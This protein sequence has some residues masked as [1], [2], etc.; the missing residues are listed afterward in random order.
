LPVADAA[1]LTTSRTLPTDHPIAPVG[2]SQAPPGAGPPATGHRGREVGANGMRGG[3]LDDA[4]KET[5]GLEHASRCIQRRKPIFVQQMGQSGH[6]GPGACGPARRLPPAGS[7]LCP[8]GAPRSSPGF[9]LLASMATSWSRAVVNRQR[10]CGG[11]DSPCADSPLPAASSPAS[12]YSG[13]P[14]HSCYFGMAGLQHGRTSGRLIARPA[15]G[16]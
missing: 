8:H 1:A 12:G 10:V 11:S 16:S 3:G 4:P 13:Q 9:I 6:V 5:E 2:D 15:H 14:R 7:P